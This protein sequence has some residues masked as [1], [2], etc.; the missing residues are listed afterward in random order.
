MYRMAKVQNN[1]QIHSMQN[2]IIDT[3]SYRNTKGAGIS[4]KLIK[5]F[6]VERFR[7]SHELC[8]GPKLNRLYV[9]AQFHD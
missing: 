3:F 6:S 2:V 8:I 7:A 4:E 1:L 9:I 5:E